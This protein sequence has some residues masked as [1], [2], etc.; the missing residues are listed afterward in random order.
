MLKLNEMKYFT[1][2]KFRE[3]AKVTSEI[4]EPSAAGEYRETWSIPRIQKA[5]ITNESQLKQMDQK[6]KKKIQ[7]SLSSLNI[8]HQKSWVN[9]NGF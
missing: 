2:S 5:G 4:G 8:C 1:V 6:K 7:V 3:F 9:F